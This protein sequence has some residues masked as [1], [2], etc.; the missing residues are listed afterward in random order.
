MILFSFFFGFLLFCFLLGAWLVAYRAEQRRRFKAVLCSG[1]P[2]VPTK[3]AVITKLEE[4]DPEII[5]VEKPPKLD[6]F[7]LVSVW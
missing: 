7:Y 5:E 2:S 3:P 6:G 4:E 1:E